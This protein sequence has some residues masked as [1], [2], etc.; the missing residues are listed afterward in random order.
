MGTEIQ[1]LLKQAFGHHQSGEWDQAEECYLEILKLEP[2]H[3]DATQYL[4]ILAYQQQQYVKSVEYL[5]RC[6]GLGQ[7]S[8]SLIFQVQN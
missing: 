4:G 7:R 5:E 8:A 3:L 6:I 2:N 1:K